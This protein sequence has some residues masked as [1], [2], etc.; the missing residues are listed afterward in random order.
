MKRHLSYRLVQALGI[1]A[2]IITASLVALGGDETEPAHDSDE[3]PT[4]VMK[5]IDDQYRGARSRGIM[6]MKV[7][8]K[9]WTRKM[10]LESWSLGENYSLM[11]ILKPRKEKGSATLK[12]KNDLFTYLNK[13]GRTIKITSGMMGGSWMGSHFTNDDLMRHTRLSE[14]FI[15]KL[16][17]EGEAGGN[18]ICRFTLVPRPDAPVVWGKIEISVRQSDLQPV[19]QVFYDEEG[20]KVRTLEFSEYK[21]VS[22]RVIPTRMVIKPL[23]GSGEY[24]MITWKEIDFDVKLEKSFFSIQK[25]RSL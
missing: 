14:D 2:L 1:V 3:F 8:T 25:L 19:S 24:T 15:I 13:T 12:A 6:E 5:K 20:K 16:S 7:K 9:H 11:R 18:D 22:G 17:F 10:E 21:T 4:Y 23:D